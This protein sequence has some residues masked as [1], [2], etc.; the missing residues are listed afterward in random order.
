MIDVAFGKMRSATNVNH[1]LRE[2]K[3][4]RQ[5]MHR[6]RPTGESFDHRPA[7]WVTQSRICTAG[8]AER[9]RLVPRVHARN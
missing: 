5:S 9:L 6:G 8:S 4:F 3:R 7:G 2:C 1:L